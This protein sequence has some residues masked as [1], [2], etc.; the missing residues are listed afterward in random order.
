MTIC[1]C[2]NNT[3]KGDIFKAFDQNFCS[4]YCRNLYI[5]N[6]K[7]TYNFDHVPNNLTSNILQYYNQQNHIV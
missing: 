1:Y 7:Y 5:S 3:F 2:C 4:E 6:H